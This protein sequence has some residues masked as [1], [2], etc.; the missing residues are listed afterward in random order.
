[1]TCNGGGGGGGMASESHKSTPRDYCVGFSRGQV[2]CGWRHHNA[3]HD[4]EVGMRQVHAPCDVIC[5]HGDGH[6]YDKDDIQVKYMSSA[7]MMESQE[8]AP[9]SAQRQVRAAHALVGEVKPHQETIDF[10]G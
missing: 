9:A 7:Q 3:A 10:R 2:V 1:M 6:E 5:L 4:D 8:A